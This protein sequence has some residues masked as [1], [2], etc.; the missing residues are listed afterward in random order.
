M[1]FKV[2]TLPLKF[3]PSL[4]G[5]SL[6]YVYCIKSAYKRSWR[7]NKHPPKRENQRVN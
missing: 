3:K 7:E 1:F 6:T 4:C 2:S 5:A